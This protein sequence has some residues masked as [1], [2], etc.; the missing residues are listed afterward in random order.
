MNGYNFR[1]GKYI[2]GVAR[3][4]KVGATNFFPGKVKKQKKKKK[5]CVDIVDRGRVYNLM[6]FLLNYWVMFNLY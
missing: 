3:R 1:Y 4:R 6:H 2:S 5:N